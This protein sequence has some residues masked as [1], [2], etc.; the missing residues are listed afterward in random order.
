MPATATM[1]AAAQAQTAQQ[2]HMQRFCPDNVQ[3]N[4]KQLY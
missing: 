3:H 4:A 2:L 1:D